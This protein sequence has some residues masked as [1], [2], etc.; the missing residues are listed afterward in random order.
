V[1]SSIFQRVRQ[2]EYRRG[3][4]FGIQKAQ[5]KQNWLVLRGLFFLT[6]PFFWEHRPV[7]NSNVQPYRQISSRA[8]R[9]GEF[10]S[11]LAMSGVGKAPAYKKSGARNG[12]PPSG[13]RAGMLIIRGSMCRCSQRSS[14][15]R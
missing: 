5:G 15:Q 2:Q 10:G 8:L 11:Q 9:H 12:T 14:P 3:S 1:K 7:R 13:F 4:F 6:P